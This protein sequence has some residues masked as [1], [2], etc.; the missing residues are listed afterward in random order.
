MVPAPCPSTAPVPPPAYQR[1][2]AKRGPARHLD[3]LTLVTRLHL[4]TLCRLAVQQAQRPCPPPLPKG[5]G[6]RPAPAATAPR[7]CC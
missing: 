7:R 5:P 2:L 4:L 3:A 6:G 1:A